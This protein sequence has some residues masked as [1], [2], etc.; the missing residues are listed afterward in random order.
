V[1]EGR[2]WIRSVCLAVD[3]RGLL[4]NNQ[5][6]TRAN[7]VVFE[8]CKIFFLQCDVGKAAT[9]IELFREGA[10]QDAC[11]QEHVK[12]LIDIVRQAW[13]VPDLDVTLR[14]CRLSSRGK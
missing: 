2:L 9:K 3:H 6:R 4:I 7:S 12:S 13:K 1:K 11:H 5:T 14:D 10:V 8:H